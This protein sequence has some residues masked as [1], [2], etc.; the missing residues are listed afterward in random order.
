MQ[1]SAQINNY[2][3]SIPPG[4]IITYQDFRDLQKSKPQALAKALERLVK[5]QVLIRQAKGTFYRPKKTIFGQ[6]S[7]SDF[8][9]CWN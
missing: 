3:K 2:I 1:V 5:K 7:P 8:T 4:K 9:I 6:V